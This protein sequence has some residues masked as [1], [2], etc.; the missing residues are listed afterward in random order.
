VA[1]NLPRITIGEWAPFEW[2]YYH[3]PG[4]AQVRSL[5][6]AGVFAQ[7]S[8]A[9]LSALLFHAMLGKTAAEHGAGPRGSVLRRWGSALSPVAVF[10]LAALAL[11]ELWQPR[12]DSVPVPDPAL[13][14]PFTDWMVEH[15]PEDRGFLTLPMEWSEMIQWMYLAPMHRRKLA[16]GYSSNFPKAYIALHDAVKED[17]LSERTRTMLCRKR[18]SHVSIRRTWRESAGLGEPDPSHFPKLHDDPVL[19]L[20]VYA[21]SCQ[22]Q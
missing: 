11:F 19:G 7:L 6:R 22:D 21:V 3:V 9:L 10:L 13:H 1:A 17:F 15:V 20:D 16:A 14:R 4:V 8:L 18:V 2:F 5:W 12:Q